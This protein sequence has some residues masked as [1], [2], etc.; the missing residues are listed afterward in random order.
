MIAATSINSDSVVTTLY[1]AIG[2][3]VALA[4]HE[5]A[6]AW[7]AVRL[8][9]ITPRQSGRLT[10]DPRPHVDPFGTLILPGILLLVVFLGQPSLLFGGSPFV[11]GYAKPQP[12]NPW[13]LRR[14]DKHLVLI[15]LAGPGANVL[16]AFAF[17]G[18]F[19][20]VAPTTGTAIGAASP[21]A[22]L[23]DCLIVSVILAAM[24]LIP[25]PPLDMTR[26]VA[27]ALP[28]RAREVLTNL[29]QYG[30][31]FMLLIFFIFPGP[32]FSFARAIG[33]GICQVTAGGSC[34]P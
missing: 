12:L 26:V 18:L 6:H 25:I 24:N 2:F 22:F 23:A 8:G 5:Y 16:L 19:R 31:L 34:F 4:V 13:A 32:V 17:G 30:A 27:R 9:D 33:N 29:E 3:V 21:A 1:L 14:Q 20:L 10:L 11:F 7:V 28:L 15:S